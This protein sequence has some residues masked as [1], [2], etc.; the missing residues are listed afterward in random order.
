VNGWIVL[1]IVVAVIAL[2]AVASK[3]G[4]IDLSNKI[5]RSGS[6]GVG[7]GAIDEIYNPSQY[8]AQLE[9]DRQTIVP[10][11]APVAGD[12][13]KGIQDAAEGQYSGRMS[14]NLD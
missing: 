7:F 8:E 11:P 3:L 12:G 6:S 14:I 13:D 4:W 9:M 2:A 10:A 1:G 5:G